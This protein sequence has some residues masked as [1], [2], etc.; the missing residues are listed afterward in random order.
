MEWGVRAGPMSYRN[1]MNLLNWVKVINHNIHY[2]FMNA[3]T[4][5]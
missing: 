3:L 2:K 4:Y 1:L 5:K